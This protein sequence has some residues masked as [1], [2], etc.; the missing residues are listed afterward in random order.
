M[1]SLDD[2]A[3]QSEGL[4]TL[5]EDVRSG[6]VSH[7]VLLTGTVGTGKRTLARLLA[8]YFLCTSS[9][10]RPCMQCKGCRRVMNGTHPD[11]LMPTCSE[12]ERSVKVEHL[13]EIIHALSMHSVEA[14]TP[15]PT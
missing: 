2:F 12:K 15:Q 14:I 3:A 1:V 10:Q 6:R 8:C 5:I 13:R 4:A 7:A 11:L 9:T